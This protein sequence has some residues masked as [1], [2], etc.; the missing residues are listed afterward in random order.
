M[1]VKEQKAR[2]ILNELM[3]GM[4]PLVRVHAN[5]AQL[6]FDTLSLL[7]QILVPTLRPVSVKTDC[8]VVM[9]LDGTPAHLYKGADLGIG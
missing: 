9:C 2:Q 3:E 5:S 6:V 8:C 7:L 1:L 4:A